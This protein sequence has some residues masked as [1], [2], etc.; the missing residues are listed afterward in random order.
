MYRVGWMH[1]NKTLLL[2]VLFSTLLTTFSPELKIVSATQPGSAVPSE[3]APANVSPRTI[4]T[5]NLAFDSLNPFYR[6]PFGAQPYT[7]T[8]YL[9]FVTG[10]GEAASVQVRFY[11]LNAAAE[12]YQS[13]TKVASDNGKDYYSIQVPGQTKPNIIYYKFKINGVGGDTVWYEEQE[14]S[15]GGFGK[16][17]TTDLDYS[18]HVTFYDPNFKTPD[19]MKQAVLYQIFPDRFFNGD[20]SNDSNGMSSV[21]TNT[22]VNNVK[23]HSFDATTG[24]EWATT[25]PDNPPQG[26]DFFGGDIKGIDLKLQ[27]DYFTNLGVTALYLNPIFF[28]PSNHK[29]DTSNYLAIDPR[30]GTM[31]DFDQ[32]VSDAHAKNIK[33]ILDGVF[34]HTS[35]DS[36]YFNRYGH[37]DTNTPFNP[38]NPMAVYTTTGNAYNSGAYKDAASPYTP[39]YHFGS[40]PPAYPNPAYDAWAGY[41]SL[42]KLYPDQSAAN[43]TAPASEPTYIITDVAQYYVSSHSINGWRLDVANEINNE[44]GDNQNHNFL[45]NFRTGVKSADPNAVIISE[46]WFDASA[47]FLGDQMDSTMNYRFRNAVEG[48]LAG[49]TDHDQPDPNQTYNVDQFNQ[50][51]LTMQEDYPPQVFYDLMNLVDSHDRPRLRMEL[52]DCD[53]T[54][55][56]SGDAGWTADYNQHCTSPSQ[57]TIDARQKLVAL[58]QFSYPGAPQIYYGDEAGMT[59]F[60]D[61]DDRRPYPWYSGQISHSNILSYYQGLGQ[62]RNSNSVLITGSLTTLYTNNSNGTYAFGR[63]TDDGQTAAVVVVN[64]QPN[65]TT[66]TIP[67]NSLGSGY[68]ANYLPEGTQLKDLAPNGNP[69]TTYTVQNGNIIIAN[70]NGYQGFV[71][72]TLASLLIPDA[73]G[74]L[75]ATAG[76][77]NNI[78]LVWPAAAHATSYNVYR[79]Y[80]KGGGYTLLGSTNGTTYTD[81]AAI[82]GNIYYYTVKASNAGL[83]G[84]ASPEAVHANAYTIGYANLQ[85]PPTTS[86]TVNTNT[87][88]IYGQIYIAGVTDVADANGNKCAAVPGLIAQ[89]GYGTQNTNPQNDPSWMW[90]STTFNALHQ[91][92]NCGNNA[93]YMGNILPGQAGTYDYV[94]RYSTDGGQTYYIG[95]YDQ[96]NPPAPPSSSAGC[97]NSNSVHGVLTVTYPNG[98]R[99][100]SLSTNQLSFVANAGAATSSSQ[101]V[102]LRATAVDVKWGSAISYSPGAKNW[103][104]LTPGNGWLL[105]G[106]SQLLSFEAN[107]AGLGAGTYT[108]TVTLGD[109]ANPAT[110]VLVNVTLSIAPS[111]TGLHTYYLPYLSNGADGFTTYLTVQNLGTAAANLSMQYYSQAT[112]LASD[113]VGGLAVHAQWVPANKLASGTSGGAILTSDQPLNILVSESTPDGGSAYT[114]RSEAGSQLVAPL[115]LNDAFG[116]FTTRLTIF[117]TGATASSVNVNFYDADGNHFGAADQTF[118]LPAHASQLIDQTRIGLPRGFAGWA[119]ISGSN[120]SQL[121]GQILEQNPISR[122]VAIANVQL[123]SAN[124]I[125][126]P[127]YTLYAPTIFNRAYGSF[128]TGANIVN[129]N[130][131][132][133][134]VTITYHAADGSIPRG[135]T[136]TYTLPAFG[137][138]S[139]YNGDASLGLPLGFTGSAVVSSTGGPVVMLVNENGG[140]TANG[141]SQS[142]VYLALNSGSASVGLPAIAKNAQGGFVTGSTILNL[143]SSSAQVSVQYF[144]TSGTAVGAENY[145]IAPAA[146]QD[147]F[148][149]AS[150]ILPDNFFGSAVIS[151]I[152]GDSG[153]QLAVVTNAASPSLFYTYIEP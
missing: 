6:T 16:S 91:S 117:N 146:R 57:A 17:Y 56:L 67:V 114:V 90:F 60:Q 106:N 108:A 152:G 31:A 28:A 132:T 112:T 148:A 4:T 55:F 115:A 81:S 36:Y 30:F 99:G 107:P 41:D 10:A 46:I 119:R 53:T 130:N 131:Q 48:F 95:C 129:P 116:G 145:N 123:Q 2:L 69:A 134:Q 24:G 104:S 43:Q 73:P 25:R 7:A 59:G 80:F 13:M 144:D 27:A 118:N 151:V 88:P 94:Y 9:H 100:L 84:V 78:N 33:I 93:E 138:Q 79:S 21:Y 125:V 11:D 111:S 85:F 126:A 137:V 128:V 121:V 76:S 82:K 72:K 71:L 113:G 44:N 141:N 38:A 139:L 97:N 147:I 20:P 77:G 52:G 92:P 74:S 63:K 105:A 109:A 103:L 49:G 87:P 62:M 29:Y 70:A 14:S 26:T 64:N 127:N 135:S 22:G 1:Q 96:T 47:W 122:F 65:I 35:S 51:L 15:T 39:W 150:A 42:P 45:K 8:V 34:N 5:A 102:A 66:L 68:L 58:M 143:G 32:L 18:W 101:M 124:P 149:G 83:E 142:G 37:F 12:S 110:Q 23:V 75:S 133:V 120:G 19:W 136:R 86:T 89:V 140:K 40:Y 61:P 153:S 50:H 54:N 3:A 98:L